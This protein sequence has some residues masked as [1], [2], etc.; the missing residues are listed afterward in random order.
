MAFY[1]Q[2]TPLPPQEKCNHANFN[3]YFEKCDDCGTTL[4]QLPQEMQDAWHAQFDDEDT[5]EQLMER[6]EN[7][8][9]G[10]REDGFNV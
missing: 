6:A 9:D 5:P 10:L 4:E 2:F 3:E 1:D 8:R 7:I